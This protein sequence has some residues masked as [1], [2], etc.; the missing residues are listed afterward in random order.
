MDMVALPFLESTLIDGNKRPAIMMGKS[1]ERDRG[2]EDVQKMIEVCGR[3]VRDDG[4]FSAEV[5]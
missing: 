2:I 5:W 1:P 3:A 4:Q